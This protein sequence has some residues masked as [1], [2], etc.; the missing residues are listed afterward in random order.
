MIGLLQSFSK[1]AVVSPSVFSPLDT[2]H[3]E[4]FKI[5][6]W[7]PE[8][9]RLKQRNT[10]LSKFFCG[11]KTTYLVRLKI[12]KYNFGKPDLSKISKEF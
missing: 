11:L 2:E 6:D 3:V 1:M 9:V 10:K 8:N 5:Y 7:H 4:N 12:Q